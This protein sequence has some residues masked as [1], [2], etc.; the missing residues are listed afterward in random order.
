MYNS[1]SFIPAYHDQLTIVL[2]H[3]LVCL[4]GYRVPTCYECLKVCWKMYS[5]T[6]FLRW[7]MW[8][9]TLLLREQGHTAAFKHTGLK[10]SLEMFIT[11]W[12]SVCKLPLC[13]CLCHLRFPDK[14]RS[15]NRNKTQM[16][17]AWNWLN[18][19]LNCKNSAEALAALFGWFMD[20]SPPL[21]HLIQLKIQFLSRLEWHSSLCS[22]DFS[23]NAFVWVT[24][25][26]KSWHHIWTPSKDKHL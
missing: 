10:F 26:E 12:V 11:M 13:L 25:N 17:L 18:S 22:Y 14:L 19:S 2:P 24:W 3:S 1:L 16:S 4:H 6:I 9:C 21:L 23:K 15:V 8:E 7:D 20:V 5:R